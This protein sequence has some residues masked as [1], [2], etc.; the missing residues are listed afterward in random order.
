M[1]RGNGPGWWYTDYGDQNVKCTP[2]LSQKYQNN[3]LILNSGFKSGR[4]QK[5][6][7]QSWTFLSPVLSGL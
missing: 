5:E 2:D 1:E 7:W 3:Q 6:T 4:I